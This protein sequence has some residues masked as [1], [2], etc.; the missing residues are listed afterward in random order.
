MDGLGYV[1][2]HRGGPWYWRVLVYR[3]A[4]QASGHAGRASP[5]V[6]RGADPWA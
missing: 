4:A 2:A 3:R 1:P 6:R 5:G